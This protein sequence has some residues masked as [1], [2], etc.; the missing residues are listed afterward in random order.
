M[1]IWADT[2]TLAIFTYVAHGFQTTTGRTSL[3]CAAICYAV[4]V[5]GITVH[6]G[7]LFFPVPI[8]GE[9]PV[10]YFSSQGFAVIDLALITAFIFMIRRALAEE[11][12]FLEDPE[13]V[14]IEMER[15]RRRKDMSR[16]LTLINGIMLLSFV[17]MLMKAGIMNGLFFLLLLWCFAYALGKYF[18]A[19][20]PL[21]PGK[22][23]VREWIERFFAK[24]AEAKAGK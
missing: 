15:P 3:F 20:V 4:A 14:G 21:P 18:E 24:P 2:A 11:A 12:R 23:K 19:V 7:T 17:P 10:K 22:S 6:F 9:I 5:L 1:L 16:I 8:L 13:V